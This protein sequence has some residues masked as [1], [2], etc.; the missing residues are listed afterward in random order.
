MP[1][2][3]HEVYWGEGGGSYAGSGDTDYDNAH[4]RTSTTGGDQPH[5]NIP[6]YEVVNR[7]YRNA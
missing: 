7:W 6:P 4:Q 5:N 1:A 2:H 3:D